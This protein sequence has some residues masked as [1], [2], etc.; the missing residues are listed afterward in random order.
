MYPVVNFILVNIINGF[1]D[2]VHFLLRFP[3]QAFQPVPFVS[4]GEQRCQV[5]VLCPVLSDALFRRCQ[6]LVYGERFEQNTGNPAC[7]SSFSVMLPEA[8]IASTGMV[9][10]FPMSDERSSSSTS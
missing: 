2:A 5:D 1:P 9:R 7:F 10:E 3:Y 8:V 4:I 6:Q